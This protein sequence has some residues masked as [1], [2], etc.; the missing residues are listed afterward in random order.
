[1][2]LTQHPV[3]KAS[4][5]ALALVPADIILNVAGQELDLNASH[6]CVCGWVVRAAIEKVKVAP[7]DAGGDHNPG[8]CVEF[9]GGNVDDWKALFMG[10]IGNFQC[11]SQERDETQIAATEL[12]FV[13]RVN[14][15]V[16]ELS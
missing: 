11:H 15:A 6:S 12:A 5:R 9:F 8:E 1:M 16:G 10:V 7:T 3:Y 4:R 14:E 2:K 13:D